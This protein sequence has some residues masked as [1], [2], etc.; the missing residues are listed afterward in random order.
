MWGGQEQVTECNCYHLLQ[1]VATDGSFAEVASAKDVYANCV[2]AL[3]GEVA[4]RRRVLGEL[5]ALLT[6][7]V[8]RVGG[9]GYAA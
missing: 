7:Q 4:A 3:Q 9:V 1:S 6:R 8:G 5:R 2:K